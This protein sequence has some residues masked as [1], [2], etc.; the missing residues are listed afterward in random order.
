MPP[1]TDRGTKCSSP[2]VNEEL[3]I[4][5]PRPRLRFLKTGENRGDGDSSATECSDSSVPSCLDRLAKFV[6]SFSCSE[7]SSSSNQ[8]RLRLN[9]T[10]P[11]RSIAGRLSSTIVPIAFAPGSPPSAVPGKHASTDFACNR[12]EFFENE[13]SPSL[14]S[15]WWGTKADYQYRNRTG[16]RKLNIPFRNHGLSR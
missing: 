15:I 16:R 9:G 5:H 4:H 10:D 6:R 8:S 3:A 14:D 1:S 7:S 2:S 11:F 12:K 13:A